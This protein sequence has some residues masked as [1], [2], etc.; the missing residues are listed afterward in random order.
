MLSA[1]CLL[2]KLKVRKPV[3]PSSPSILV[4]LFLPRKSDLK[5]L[6]MGRFSIVCKA[7][8]RNG[9]EAIFLTRCSAHPYAI[10]SVLEVRQ[11]CPMPHA[12]NLAQLVLNQ[13]EVVKFGIR[14][15]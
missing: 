2:C 3:R 8:V 5:L 6:E 7:S 1:V 9:L 4:I 13:V 15:R 12:F 10:P 11:I 14:V